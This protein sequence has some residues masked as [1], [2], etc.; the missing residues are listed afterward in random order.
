MRRLEWGLVA[1]GIGVAIAA[2]LGPLALGVIQ[3]HVTDEVR[4][5]VV[6]GGHR[7]PAW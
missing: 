4:N 2:L 3:Y 7:G 5:Q 6:G 1:L